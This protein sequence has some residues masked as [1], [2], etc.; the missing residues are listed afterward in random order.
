VLAEHMPFVFLQK[1]V[2]QRILF[3]QTQIELYV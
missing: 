1:Y 2:Y 3:F